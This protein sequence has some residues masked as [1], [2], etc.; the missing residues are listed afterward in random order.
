MNL[1]LGTAQFGL[2]Y[3]V[4]EPSRSV[5][6]RKVREILEI[7]WK[8]GV[9][10]LD[11]AQ[12]YGDVEEILGE[13]GV[14]HFKI[15]NKISVSSMQSSASSS[16]VEDSLLTSLRKLKVDCLEGVLFH[17]PGSL[18]TEFGNDCY[19]RLQEARS[20]GLLKKIGVSVYTPMEL[21]R[22]LS[23]FQF[24]IVQCPINLADRRFLDSG[25]VAACIDNGIEVHARSIF[26]QGLLLAKAAEI[27]DKFSP[28]QEGFANLAGWV[29]SQGVSHIQAA[30]NFVTQLREVS[31]VLVGV[32]SP[33]HLL[34]ICGASLREELPEPPIFFGQN[35]ALID[36]RAWGSL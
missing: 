21:Q 35:E 1:V 20:S 32:D 28:W 2:P 26:L 30:L 3:G 15:I 22:L 31:G 7:A 17:D 23:E 14:K 36:P 19:I 24:D 8:N 16:A 27:P 4:F 10:T 11:T 6:N 12:A 34:E 18:F 29:Q 9:R 13:I 25:L 33:E 5:P